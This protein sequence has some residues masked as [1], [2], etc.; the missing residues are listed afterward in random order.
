MGF[1]ED[2]D[3]IVEALNQRFSELG[4]GQPIPYSDG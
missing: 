1:R 4:R 2:R 3:L